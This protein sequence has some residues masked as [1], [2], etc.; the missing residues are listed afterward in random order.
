MKSSVSLATAAF[1]ALSALAAMAQEEARTPEGRMGP[2]LDG[3]LPP[4]TPGTVEGWQ[5]TRA[6]PRLTFTDVM[7]IERAPRGRRLHVAFLAGGH[8][9]SGR[10]FPY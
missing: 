8:R 2:F 10:L 6:V 4:R 9:A 3:V 1:A 5:L 7:D